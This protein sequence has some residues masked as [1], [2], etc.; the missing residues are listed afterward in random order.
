MGNS[1]RVMSIIENMLKS[2]ETLDIRELAFRTSIPKSSV[3]RILDSLASDGW[4]TQ[5][6][7]SQ[8]YRISFKLLNLVNTW[9]L[10][11]E[12]TR[13]AHVE[14]NILC[15]KS[16]QTILLL[17]LDGFRGICQDKVEPERT[18]KLVA[19]T[20]KAFPLHAAACGK[21]LLAYAPVDL[22]ERII[23]STLESFTP[24]TI[25]D[26]DKLK[27]EILDIRA[28]GRAISVEEMTYGAAEIAIPLLSNDGSLIA[29]LSIAGPMFDV[30]P[31]LEI[32]EGLLRE[33]ATRII[34]KLKENKSDNG[35]EEKI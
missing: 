9:H 3:Q 14:M 20:G 4:V 27:D 30:K 16:Q 2:E 33:A 22:Q 23:N 17:V 11:Q 8:N 29:A 18:I 31:K 13:C 15:E 5:D 10:K 7:T 21:I 34:G 32:Y 26:V 35:E 12:L 6:H 25:T 28:N 1:L 19:E 24:L